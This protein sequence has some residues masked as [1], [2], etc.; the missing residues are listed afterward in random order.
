[1]STG[2]PPTKNKPKTNN[3]LK[4]QVKIKETKK[5][6]KLTGLGFSPT[7]SGISWFG[8][9]MRIRVRVSASE[10]VSFSRMYSSLCSQKAKGKCSDGQK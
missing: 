7:Q 5:L 3:F 6:G 1:M 8:V 2:V 9:K 4:M 10:L